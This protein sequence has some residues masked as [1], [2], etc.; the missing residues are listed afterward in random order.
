MGSHSPAT[1]VPY[2]QPPLQTRKQPQS[3][4]G[5]PKL[6]PI[7]SVPTI[8]VFEFRYPCIL[9]PET[10][11][12]HSCSSSASSCHFIPRRDLTTF[13]LAQKP[14]P[15][16]STPHP[17]ISTS[18]PYQVPPQRETDELHGITVPEQKI[19]FPLMAPAG[20]GSL[21]GSAT[22]SYRFEAD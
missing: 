1:P 6:N 16:Q 5:Y 18:R 21:H 17:N 12:Q 15:Y 4:A 22:T 8:E 3:A 20:Y 2:P 14:N 9:P 7:T 10:V 19:A 13:N 11:S